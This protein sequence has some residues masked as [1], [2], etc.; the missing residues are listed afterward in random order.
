M[1]PKH[2][3]PKGAKAPKHQAPL[4]APFV[5]APTHLTPFLSTLTPN[6]TIHITHLDTHPVPL[7]QRAFAIPA[8]LNTTLIAAL[9]YRAYTRAP[10]YTAL[11]LYAL[12]RPTAPIQAP[13]S[14]TGREIA[15]LIAV[16]LGAFAVDYILFALLAAWPRT[17]FLDPASP[18]RWRGAVG[19][20][21]RELVVRSSTGF[22][23][24]DL[25]RELGERPDGSGECFGWVRDAVEPRLM[26]RTGLAQVGPR[27][28]LNVPAMVEAVAG[29]GEWT[30]EDVHGKV[31]AFFPAGENG[32]KWGVWDVAPMIG[33]AENPA[34]RARIFA[35]QDKLMGMGKEEL[36]YKWV[37]LIQYESTRPGGFGVEAQERAGERVRELFGSYGVDFEG[38]ERE[39]NGGIGG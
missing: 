32:G 34:G 37:E 2:R 6:T 21:D 5:P 19:F 3:P 35:I 24:A 23:C 1:P 22:D 18:L 15:W 11:V 13:P 8:I 26:A 25:A 12:R 28:R 14:A 30:A 20:A 38:F 9:F 17:F 16:R 27:W 36:F 4:P 10:F 31:W 33:A 7:K 39:V 29:E